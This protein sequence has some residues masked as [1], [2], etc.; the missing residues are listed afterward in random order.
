MADAEE[1]SVTPGTAVCVRSALHKAGAVRLSGKHS[2]WKR[3][4]KGFVTGEKLAM[5]RE[6]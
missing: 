3:V 2:S 1:T 6:K 4:Q 5:P